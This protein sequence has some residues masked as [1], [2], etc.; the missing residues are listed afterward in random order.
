MIRVLGHRGRCDDNKTE[1]YQNTPP[2][3][4]HALSYADGLEMD[5]AISADKNIF[6]VH[7]VF[8]SGDSTRYMVADHLDKKSVE[9]LADRHLNEMP[10]ED[11]L[12]L[13]THNNV[14]FPLF[15][16]F[17]EIISSYPDAQ[18]NVELKN[19]GTAEFVIEQCDKAVEEGKIT[20]DQIMIS[21]FNYFELLTCRQLNCGYRLSLLVEPSSTPGAKMYDWMP[22]SDAYFTPLTESLLNS[23]AVKKINPWSINI[24]E[25]DLT[26]DNIKMIKS[27]FPDAQ[28]L[29]WWWA[30]NPE[31]LPEEN[32]TLFAK[33]KALKEADLLD[34]LYAIISNYPKEMKKIISS[35]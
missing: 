9:I 7:D 32:K 33:L 8:F 2:A 6:V 17:I 19:H 1:E 16:E 20:R 25:S 29:T 21:S 10:I 18:I 28:I 5:V 13:K 26:V 15:S 14:S 35:I 11:I 24:E 12:S 34:S 27:V 30:G 4:L 22:E 3:F 23:E 31:P